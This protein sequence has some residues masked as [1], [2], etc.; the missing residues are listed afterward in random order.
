MIAVV[1]F[2][3][4]FVGSV[5][6]NRTVKDELTAALRRPSAR[7]RISVTD[8]VNPRQAFFRWTRPDIQPSPDRRQSLLAGTGFHSQFGAAIS[9]EEFVE[10]FVEFE[11]IVGKIDIYEDMPLE[12]KTTA[13]V[14]EGAEAARP[15][16]VDQLAMYCAMVGVPRGRLVV[17]GRGGPPQPVRLRA[18][19]VEFADLDGIRAEMRRRRDALARALESGSPGDLPRCEWFG[20]GCDYHD[21]CGC[22]AAPPLERV[23]APGSVALQPDPALE[24]ALTARVRA[25]PAPA[26][27]RLTDLVFPRRS[28]YARLSPAEGDA[29]DD[30]EARLQD[31][32]RRGFR[33]A[34]YDTLRFGVPGAF[35]TVPVRLRSLADRVDTYHGIP[36]LLRV[37]SRFEMV[38]R[39]RI[40]H[41]LGHHVD[42]LAFACAL[43]QAEMGRLIVYYE[44]LGDKFM[45]YDLQFRDLPQIRA[46]ADRRLALLEAG[47]PPDQLP[48]CPTWMVQFCRFAPGC[49]CGGVPA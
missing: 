26:G 25:A 47:A 44:R 13:V 37:S 19:A 32:A 12:L 27:L 46:E 5:E 3:A 1:A 35:R 15:T 22:E 34:L 39:R 28:A 43:L 7:R 16:Y 36:T 11:G 40:P 31:M 30:A 29:I 41:A 9:T 24:S 2:A 38:E 17:Y 10:Q 4:P 33:D 45:V 14:P 42:R 48:P 20:R 21:I 23:V 18:F 49:G 8:L 6:A